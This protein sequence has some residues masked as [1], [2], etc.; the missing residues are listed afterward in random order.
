MALARALRRRTGAGRYRS[1]RD[2]DDELGGF[3]IVL[4]SGVGEVEDG[5]RREVFP[6]G[7]GL[8]DQLDHVVKRP[9]VEASRHDGDEEDVAEGEGSPKRGRIAPP[10][11]DDDVVIF[12]GLELHL[13]AQ[14]TAIGI[15]AACNRRTVSAL[16]ARRNRGEGGGLPVSI[17]QP[18]IAALAGATDREV[19]SE[20]GLSDA[21]LSMPP[22]R[23]R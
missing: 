3:V 11:V 20:R 2:A 7:A 23:F 13:A 21:A 18:D 22:R 6:D 19:E 17:D 10:G 8:L 1:A 4:A 9:D 15:G 14:D 5:E 12:R 16:V